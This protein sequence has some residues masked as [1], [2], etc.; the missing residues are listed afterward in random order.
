[1]NG[2]YPNAR[3]RLSYL[4]PDGKRH[5]IE[6]ETV[7]AQVDSTTYHECPVIFLRQLKERPPAPT[8][9][10]QLALAILDG[11]DNAAFAASDDLQEWRARPDGFVSREELVALLRDAQW[12]FDAVNQPRCVC[13]DATR[14]N[15]HKPDCRL[16]A[17]LGVNREE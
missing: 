9:E 12:R 17:A 1:M 16:A 14:K 5:W 3:I 6:W 4:T 10:H 8:L 11:D 7:E 15:D 2:V 13:C